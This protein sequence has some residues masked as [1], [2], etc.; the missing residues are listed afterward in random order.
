MRKD[1]IMKH[2]FKPETR[3]RGLRFLGVI[4]FV[5]IIW[6]L[7]SLVWLPSV[8][9]DE[10]KKQ[11]STALYY[12]VKLTPSEASAPRKETRPTRS[13]GTINDIR[14]LAIY[15][16]SDITVITVEYKRKTKVLETGESINGFTLEGASNAFARFSKAGKSYQVKLVKNA[17]QS[18][19]NSTIRD[20]DKDVKKSIDSAPQGEVR[21]VGDYKI[22]DR[23]LF[24]HYAK[25]MDDIYKNIGI[26]EV[27][28]GN[29]VVGF[30]VNFVRR[31]SPFAKLGIKRNDVIKS[32][33]GQALTSYA[34][35]MDVYKN[36][37]DVANLSV[38]ILRGKEEMELEY[39]IN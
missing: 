23:S 9:L 13:S 38:V 30:K 15:H 28:K 4:L 12:R 24:D 10:A 16:A 20:A 36:M 2:L 37:K 7:I 19:T 29:N 1:G 32:I 31:N 26:A 27:K 17:K 21:D 8:D 34:A 5:K 33:N 3:K 18:S 11:D 6:V 25:N 14:L 22:I 35:A 39:E